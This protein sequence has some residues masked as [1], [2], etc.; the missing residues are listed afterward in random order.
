MKANM[1]DRMHSESFPDRREMVSA[2][3]AWT[4]S[5][6][7]EWEVVSEQL[8]KPAPTENF[9]WRSTAQRLLRSSKKEGAMDIYPLCLQFCHLRKR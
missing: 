3:R 1:L 9:C 8:A 5:V 2:E 6:I 4:L 7:M